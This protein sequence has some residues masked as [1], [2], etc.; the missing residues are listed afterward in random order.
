M[1][2]AEKTSNAQVGPTDYQ[3]SANENMQKMSHNVR[4]VWRLRIIYNNFDFIQ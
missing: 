3:T 1:A 2:Q 4:Q